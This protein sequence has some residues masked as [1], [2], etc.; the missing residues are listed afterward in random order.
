MN[1]EPVVLEL[2]VEGAAKKYKLA[3]TTAG[4]Q[5]FEALSGKGIFAAM[6][7]TPSL[8]EIILL[9]FVARQGPQPW[10]Q[11]RAAEIVNLGN[12][13]AVWEALC[14]AFTRAMGREGTEEGGEEGGGEA[15]PLGGSASGSAAG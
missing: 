6:S 9:F 2:E 3:F 11:K 4:V 7:A 1:K 12:M 5:Q 14:L 13:L 15:S 10:T 8:T